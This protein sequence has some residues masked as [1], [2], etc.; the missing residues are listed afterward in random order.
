[1]MDLSGIAFLLFTPL[2]HEID[3]WRLTLKCHSRLCS[4]CF[5]EIVGNSFDN[6]VYIGNN[7]TIKLW[8]VLLYV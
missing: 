2:L 7:L 4:V 6:I 3:Q 5:T 8:I 1:M